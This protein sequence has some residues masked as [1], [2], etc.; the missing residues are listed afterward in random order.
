MDPSCATGDEKGRWLAVPFVGG[1]V[2]P[3]VPDVPDGWAMGIALAGDVVALGLSDE[4]DHG[5]GLDLVLRP[6]DDRF[7]PGLGDFA[8]A[9]PGG[10]DRPPPSAREAL[11]DA[12]PQRLPICVDHYIDII[13]AL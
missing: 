6:G 9:L 5:P 11:L 7:R 10:I 3:F 2:R 1:G 13:V 4:D 8:R 12:E